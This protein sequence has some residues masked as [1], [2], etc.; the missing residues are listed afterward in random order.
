MASINRASFAMDHFNDRYFF[1]P[2][3]A[4]VE[5][6]PSPLRAGL[7]NTIQTLAQPRIFVNDL[8]QGKVLAAGQ[9]LARFTINLTLGIA[10]L[11][12]TASWLGLPEHDEDFGQTLCLAG[13]PFGPYVY[14]PVLGPSSASEAVSITLDAALAPLDVLLPVFATRSG[15]A[16]QLAAIRSAHTSLESHTLDLYDFERVAYRQNR[17]RQVQDQP[18]SLDGEALQDKAVR[19]Y[20]TCGYRRPPV[21][22]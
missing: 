2:L 12:D 6:A 3:R 5:L 1:R 17:M 7:A 14:F 9:D 18:L 13:I 10:G 19:A 22:P 16:R 11:V 4:G 8:L 21:T 20:G 15:R